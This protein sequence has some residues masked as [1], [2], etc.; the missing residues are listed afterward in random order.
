MK[1]P[2]FQFYPTDYLGSQRV[3]MMTLD[4]EGAYIRLLSYCWQHGTIPSDPAQAARLIGKGAS[5]TLASTVLTM[6]TPASEP[7]R[8]THDRLEQERG[9]QAAWREKSAA[10]GRKSA[11]MRKGASTTLASTMQP[12]SQPKGN[13][14][15]PSPSPSPVITK[16]VGKNVPEKGSAKASPTSDVEWLKTLEGDPAYVGIPVDIEYAKMFRWCQTNNK[17]PTRRRFINWLNRAER[18]MSSNRSGQGAMLHPEL[19]AAFNNG[20]DYKP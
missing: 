9:K 4:E 17:Q 12:P 6:F 20:T 13:S 19:E 10:G 8:M 1:S 16:D 3:Q 14:P 5:T 7:G 18:P 11:E 2:A 15:S